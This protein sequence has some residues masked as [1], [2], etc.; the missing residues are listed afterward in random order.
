MEQLP[1]LEQVDDEA[2]PAVPQETL[3]LLSGTSAAA[4]D[5]SKM[6]SFTPPGFEVKFTNVFKLI[7]FI[8]NLK[9]LFL[10]NVKY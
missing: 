10:F 6:F 7:V 2:P 8:E 1:L 5:A 9:F 4:L 3:M